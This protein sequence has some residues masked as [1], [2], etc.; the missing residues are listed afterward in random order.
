MVREEVHTR[1]WLGNLRERNHLE[2]LVVDGG[3]I[4]KCIFKKWNGGVWTGLIWLKIGTG[5]GLL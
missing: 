3:I 5:D 2:D 1:F 4:L